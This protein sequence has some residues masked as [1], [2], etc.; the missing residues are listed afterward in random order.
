MGTWLIADW[1]DHWLVCFLQLIC[2]QS[3]NLIFLLNL[4][5]TSSTNQRKG[6]TR[7]WRFLLVILLL[8]SILKSK[9]DELDIRVYLE[10]A[11]KTLNDEEKR[12]TAYLDP[13]TLRPLVKLC[14]TNFI[15]MCLIE[16]FRQLWFIRVKYDSDRVSWSVWYDDQ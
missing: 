6:L 8:V 3:L 1:S 9:L 16:T 2:I 15:G 12:A 13:S 7:P 10:L 14:Q 11:E 5:N 4:T